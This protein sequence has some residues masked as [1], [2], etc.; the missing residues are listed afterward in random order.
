MNENRIL[1]TGGQ[2]F[3]G[4]GTPPVPADVVVRGNRIE[5]VRPGGGATADPEPGGPGGRLHRRHGHAG[6]GG[7]PRPPDLPLRPRAHRPVLQPAAGCQLLPP[8]A[9]TGGAPGH[10]PAQREDPARSRLHQRLLG[11]L[12]HPGPDGGAAAG[13]DRGGSGAGPADARRLLRAR[14]QPGADGPGRAQA[15]EGRPGSGARVHR[16]AGRHRL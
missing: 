1:F 15:Q 4:T 2:V 3:D 14:Q 10:R 6:P 9:H 5:S 13:A 16:R 12:A 11:R 8:H 7:V